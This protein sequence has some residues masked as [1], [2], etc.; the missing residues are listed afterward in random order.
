MNTKPVID[1]LN[2]R[3]LNDVAGGRVIMAT[4]AELSVTAT[5]DKQ[6]VA[7][8]TMTATYRPRDGN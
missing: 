1:E 4:N 3:E 5:R 7:A 8:Q 6:A 2:E